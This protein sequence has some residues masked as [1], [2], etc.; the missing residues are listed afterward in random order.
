[1]GDAADDAIR[2][3]ER[4]QEEPVWPVCDWCNL[5]D[6]T[7]ELRPACGEDTKLCDE[8]YQEAVNDVLEMA[9]AQRKMMKETDPSEW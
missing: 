3:A 8:C 4:E 1:M 5:E 2:A 6:E 9:D 7:V